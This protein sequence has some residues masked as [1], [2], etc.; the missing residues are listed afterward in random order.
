MKKRSYVLAACV[1]HWE[2]WLRRCGWSWI[3]V[4]DCTGH[5]EVTVAFVEVPVSASGFVELEQEARSCS[6]R[7]QQMSGMNYKATW[8]HK[9]APFHRNT[10]ICNSFF[11]FIRMK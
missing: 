10:P 8:L 6:S 11:S 5:S 2:R 1:V 9:I 7:P 3:E 4:L